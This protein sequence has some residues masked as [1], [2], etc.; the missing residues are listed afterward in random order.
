MNAEK[1]MARCVKRFWERVNTGAVDD[2]WTWKLPARDPFG[3]GGFYFE[4][5]SR[6]AHRVAWILTREDPGALCVLHSCDNPPCVNPRHLFLGTKADNAADRHA[7]G[8]TGWAVGERQSAA[9]LT[10]EKVREI[11]EA[12]ATGAKRKELASLY[13]VCRQVIDGIVNRQRWAHA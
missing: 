13:G 12:V 9:K 11:R 2:C 4:G 7:K 6:P 10:V 5:S 8:R 1:R 3:Y